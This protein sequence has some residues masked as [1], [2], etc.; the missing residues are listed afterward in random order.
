M[1]GSTLTW[2][3][4]RACVTSLHPFLL[5]SMKVHLPLV[6][7]LCNLIEVHISV[8]A[9]LFNVST[10]DYTTVFVILWK[11]TVS[12]IIM[13]YSSVDRGQDIQLFLWAD[14]ENV[15]QLP[16]RRGHG[17]PLRQHALSYTGD[18]FLLNVR[19][20]HKN[21]AHWKCCLHSTFELFFLFLRLQ[22]YRR[23]FCLWVPKSWAF[24]SSG[25][26]FCQYIVVVAGCFSNRV[27]LSM[28]S[29][30]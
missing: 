7:R 10:I 17:H 9:P 8:I 27:P 12:V 13:L 26:L 21:L 16:T 2:A 30:F 29:S 25:Q 18:Q 6:C 4:C 19:H 15:G 5:S 28:C 14:E 20:T 22:N 3:T 1:C 23:S 24:F 11:C